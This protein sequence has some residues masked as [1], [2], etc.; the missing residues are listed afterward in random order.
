MRA[1]PP[2]L[3]HGRM[4]LR[5]RSKAGLGRRRCAVWYP[6]VVLCVQVLSVARR[7][8]RGAREE[9]ER[10]RALAL[11]QGLRE[12][13]ERR[14]PECSAGELSTTARHLAGL[15]LLS[16][17]LLKRIA[18]WFEQRLARADSRSGLRC[19]AHILRLYRD[20][21]PLRP[22]PA[23]LASIGARLSAA[24]ASDE[25][26][27]GESASKW[28]VPVSPACAADILFAWASVCEGTALPVTVVRALAGTAVAGADAAG[29]IG[30][31][32]FAYALHSVACAVGA[33]PPAA[34]ATDS[35]S[36]MAGLQTDVA[37]WA[38]LVIEHV[39]P[40][41]PDAARDLGR[42]LHALHALEIAPDAVT[43]AAAVAK[44]AALASQ[45]DA[46]H[47][48]REVNML[49]T[50]LA[51]WH[52]S[53]LVSCEPAAHALC[54]RAPELLEQASGKGQQ[55]EVLRRLRMLASTTGVS[56]PELAGPWPRRASGGGLQEAGSLRGSG[57]G[58]GPVVHQQAPC[59]TAG[60][61][62][63]T[64]QAGARGVAPYA[65][66]RG[67]WRTAVGHTG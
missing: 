59:W 6:G 12:A 54:A 45:V 34:P 46:H 5:L 8:A 26:A 66:M 67:A 57:A 40:G 55:G 64:P 53:G 41:R 17:G 16:H 31:S 43:V 3:L 42:A 38:S 36:P 32:R 30:V 11:L 60:L 49:A 10:A 22:R 2:S 23:L 65:W 61:Q 13:F 27:T 21:A 33:A 15:G 52:R 62:S 39:Q 63:T 37:R 20:A 9:A 28:L 4:Q 1:C 14:L 29:K 56:V 58:G 35:K 50:R 7:H 24:L 44:A 51:A 25:A 19:V 48:H 47:L 18:V